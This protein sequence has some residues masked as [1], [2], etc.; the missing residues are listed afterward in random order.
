MIRQIFARIALQSA[1]V[2][3]GKNHASGG[4]RQGNVQQLRFWRVVGAIAG[5][6]CRHS[7]A[8]HVCI[9]ACRIDNDSRAVRPVTQNAEKPFAAK[10]G[11]GPINNSDVDGQP[12]AAFEKSL[13]CF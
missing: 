6:A 10:V 9:S 1:D 2:H 7:T 11:N 12:Q 8:R 4:N 3:I 5:C 13:S